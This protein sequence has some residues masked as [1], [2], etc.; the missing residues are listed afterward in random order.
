MKDKTPFVFGKIANT[1][2]FTDRDAE[3]KLKC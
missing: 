1:K 3:N 2:N